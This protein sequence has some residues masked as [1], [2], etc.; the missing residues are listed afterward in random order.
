MFLSSTIRMTSA[1]IVL[2]SIALFSAR[3]VFKSKSREMTHT[4]SIETLMV[5]DVSIVI[6]IQTGWFVDSRPRIGGIT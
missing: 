4:D 5:L 2:I 1:S 3:R 6:Q